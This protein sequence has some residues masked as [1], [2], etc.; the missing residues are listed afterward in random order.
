[1]KSLRLIRGEECV[2]CMEEYVVG[3]LISIMSCGAGK[4]YAHKACLDGWI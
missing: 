2:L 4:H 3:D 1:M